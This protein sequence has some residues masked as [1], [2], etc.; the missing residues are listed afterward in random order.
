MY[1]PESEHGINAISLVAARQQ[2]QQCRNSAGIMETAQAHCGGTANLLLWIG[3][4]PKERFH[5]TQMGKSPQRRGGAC[6]DFGFRCGKGVCKERHGSLFAHK[7]QDLS[8]EN[9]HA[10]MAAT[11][12]VEQRMD[13]DG[14][15]EVFLL[16]LETRLNLCSGKHARHPK[17]TEFLKR[18]SGLL[19]YARIVVGKPQ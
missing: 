19:V 14:T 17:I 5:R 15:S 3:Q 10:R 13:C 12:C 7:S 1:P 18:C 8:R 16:C 11:E 2:S 9:A 4:C 6:T